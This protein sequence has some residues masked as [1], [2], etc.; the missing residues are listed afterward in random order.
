MVTSAPRARGIG[1]VPT[2]SMYFVLEMRIG[3]GLSV[4]FAIEDI[5]LRGVGNRIS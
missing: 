4:T 1:I 2:G 5:L 3:G